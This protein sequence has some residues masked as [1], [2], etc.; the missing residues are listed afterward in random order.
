M[1]RKLN[2]FMRFSTLAGFGAG[3]F[4]GTTIRFLTIC[5]L[6]FIINII[7]FSYSVKHYVDTDTRQDMWPSFVSVIGYLILLIN[8]CKN[9]PK[10][11]LNQVT[12]V[13]H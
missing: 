5:A 11:N 13:S 4:S 8:A 12:N 1:F 10:D 6:S 2:N 7:A 3:Y 9:P